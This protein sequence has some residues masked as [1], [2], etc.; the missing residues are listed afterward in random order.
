MKSPMQLQADTFH[1][2]VM[3]YF[4][5]ADGLKLTWDGKKY[6]SASEAIRGLMSYAKAIPLL[7]Q[8][9]DGATALVVRRRTAEVIFSA[10]FDE[11]N[12]RWIS[13]CGGTL[14]GSIERFD[15]EA[16][17]ELQTAQNTLD[18]SPFYRTVI[19]GMEG[20]AR[21]AFDQEARQAVLD[22]RSAD[23]AV[24]NGLIGMTRLL[25]EA[26]G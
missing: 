22:G 14:E 18:A 26:C 12:R 16:E 20:P 6:S 8:I 23:D 7:S 1:R 13:Q 2:S 11:E 21:E 19:D 4:S 9:K 5:F 24:M 25:E 3:I 15:R 10:S 17:A